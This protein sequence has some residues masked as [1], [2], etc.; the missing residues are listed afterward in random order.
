MSRR[1][2]TIRTRQPAQARGL[3]PMPTKSTSVKKCTRTCGRSVLN[4]LRSNGQSRVPP[5]CQ[6]ILAEPIK[7]TLRI[8]SHDGPLQ[9]LVLTRDVV[10]Q[11]EKRKNDLTLIMIA[12]GLTV[13]PVRHDPIQMAKTQDE[14][15]LLAKCVNF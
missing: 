10:A 9:P 12:N 14:L 8:T 7:S 3:C 11:Q 13:N 2:G 15:S 4:K 6:E 1:P 5:L